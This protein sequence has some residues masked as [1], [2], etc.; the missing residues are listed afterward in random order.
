MS[1]SEAKLVLGQYLN[2]SHCP[3]RYQVQYDGS[4]DNIVVV[5]GLPIID[6]SKRDRLLTK[7]AKEFS[8]KGV[9]VRQDDIFMPWND[10]TGKNK[11]CVP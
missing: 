9:S 7:A 10:S 8:K 4:F 11:G 1:V 3:N 6:E 5:D 2:I